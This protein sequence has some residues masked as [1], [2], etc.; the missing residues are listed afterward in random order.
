[1]S[2]INH[3]AQLRSL[4]LAGPGAKH[5]RAEARRRI[6]SETPVYLPIACKLANHELA[7]IREH[8]AALVNAFLV[9]NV[10]LEVSLLALRH[11]PLP[12]SGVSACRRG[13]DGARHE[14]A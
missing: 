9:S 12:L 2:A 13:G 6:E 10:D 5:R 3:E 1:M 8:A 11:L 7:E 4:L 14:G